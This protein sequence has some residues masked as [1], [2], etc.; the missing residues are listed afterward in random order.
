MRELSAAEL[1]AIWE[2][3]M[4]LPMVERGLLLLAAAHP[5]LD[6]GELSSWPVGRRDDQLL[7]LRMALFGRQLSGTTS[8]PRCGERLELDLNGPELQPA[9]AAGP[10]AEALS[11]TTDGYEIRFRL[12]NSHDLLALEEAGDSATG[13]A[14]LL[15]ACVLEARHDGLPESAAALP[16]E[17]IGALAEQMDRADPQ[18]NTWLDLACPACSNRWQALFDIVSFAWGEVEAWAQRMLREVASLAASYGWSEADILDMSAWRRNFYL[19]M[20]GR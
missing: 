8:C 6:D 4:A 12:P 20:A 7:R 2:R 9:V 15:A 14:R 18:A 19:E 11:F 13:Y 17:V 3:G 5:E 16:P 10:P 1:L